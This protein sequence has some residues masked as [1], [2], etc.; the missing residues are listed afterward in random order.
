MV[1]L[2]ETEDHEEVEDMDRVLDRLNSRRRPLR[3][4]EEELDRALR[5]GL[6]AT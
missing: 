4:L 1:S 5:L 3:L 6:L 2:E